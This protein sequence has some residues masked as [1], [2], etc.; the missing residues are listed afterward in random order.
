MN[1]LDLTPFEKKYVYR[2]VM[3]SSAWETWAFVLSIAALIL[4]LGFFHHEVV[5]PL[6]TV[7]AAEV[8]AREIVENF[9]GETRM[10]CERY[11]AG[12]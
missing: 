1:E 9:E 4:A 5:T 11:L 12:V 7:H 8:P 2:R 3:R 6:T 10:M